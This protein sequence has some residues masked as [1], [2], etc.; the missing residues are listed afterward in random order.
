M[1]IGLQHYYLPTPTR[2]D[3][4][5]SPTTL[6]CFLNSSPQSP[7]FTTSILVR[8]SQPGTNFCLSYS[9]IAVK[10][11]W[12]KTALI[13]AFNW[14]LVYSFR[15]LVHYHS[16]KQTGMALKHSWELYIFTSSHLD[17]QVAERE[18]ADWMNNRAW[19]FG[20]SEHTSQQHTYS[21]KDISLS[22]F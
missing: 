6:T 4:S 21:N 22:P 2:V 18:G 15:G 20:P 5:A 11:H 16:G 9:S 17:P 1:H 10:R 12:L 13:K 14:W 7:L 8:L 19:A 3:C